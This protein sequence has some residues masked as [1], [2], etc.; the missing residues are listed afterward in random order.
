ML[1]WDMRLWPSLGGTTKTQWFSNVNHKGVYL[2]IKLTNITSI[3]LSLYYSGP[4]PT[5]LSPIIRQKCLIQV[6]RLGI[7]KGM[8]GGQMKLEATMSM[9]VA[10]PLATTTTGVRE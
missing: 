2:K 8:A 1:S 10:T 9:A 3:V 7:P 6:H 5:L 4:T